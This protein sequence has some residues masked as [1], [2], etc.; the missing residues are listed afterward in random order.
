MKAVNVSLGARELVDRPIPE[1]AAGE[2]LI[3]N[4]AVSS[5]PKDWKM[6]VFIEGY[7]AVEGNDV[8]GTIEAVGEGVTKFKKGDRVC[9][10]TKMVSGDQYGA[11]AEY[12]VAPACTVAKLGDKTS[13]E[14]A[15]ALPLPYATATIGLFRQMR[16]EEP[17]SSKPRD[18]A[19]LVW[20][21]ATTV[22]VYAIQL[23][24][25]AGYHVVA[26]SGSSQ[27]VATKYGADENLDYRNKSNEA[28]AA[29]IRNSNGGKG[30]KYIYDAVSENQT[31]EVAA[32]ALKGV[33]G[34]VY[35]HV[36]PLSDDELKAFS[37]NVRVIRIMCRSA[38]DDEAQAGEKWFDWLGPALEK[39]EIQPQ[40]VT[41]VPGGLEGVSEGLRRLE[42]HEVRGEKLVYRIKDTPGL[43]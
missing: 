24:K 19:V 28:L 3:K 1:P 34:A 37:D 30:V 27:D 20:G 35:G 32:L 2:V 42:H 5:N 39:G 36:L 12:S 15:A 33:E 40:R 38:Y 10:F 26:V 43:A 18:G 11:Y 8:A 41:I 6:P 17:G 13:F 9:A 31:H 22:G 16:V 7:S 23:A 25:L 4:V 29:E 21:G 14:D